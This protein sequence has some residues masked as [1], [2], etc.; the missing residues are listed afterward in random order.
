MQR[1]YEQL[2]MQHLATTDELAAGLRALPATA[3]SFAAAQAAWR[4][5]TNPH[6]SLP[7]LMQPMI[8]RARA[9]CA[10][11]CHQFGLAIHDWSGLNYSRHPSKP[12]RVVLHHRQELGYE[13]QSVLLLSDRTG[14][15]LAPVYQG[16]RAADG[17]HSTRSPHRLP[18]RSHLDEL[19]L[20][21]SHVE[22]LQ[23]GKP[24]VHVIDCEADSVLHLR[25]E[26]ARRSPSSSVPMPCGGSCLQVVRCCL[27]KS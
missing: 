27:L 4:F 11:A 6:T 16:V 7:Q 25:R 3:G 12:D 19:S 14:R 22:G 1:R 2:V 17:L 8:A 18:V 13:L 9:A 24:L 26:S 21:L 23:L 10:S 20:T 15:P 5:Y